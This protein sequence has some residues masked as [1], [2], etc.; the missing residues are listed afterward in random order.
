MRFH[1]LALPNVQTTRE[2]SL[3]GFCVATIRFAKLLKSLGHE[4]ILYA[5]EEN[6]APCDELVTV[7]T[8]E[9]IS[10][11]LGATRNRAGE[12]EVTPYQYA[13]IEEW[14][15]IW[16]LANAR[17]IR[18]ISKRKQ[19][20]DFI[21]SIGGSSQQPVARALPD[22]MFVEYSIGYL[23]SFSDFRVFESRAWQHVVYGQQNVQC[24]RFFDTVIPCSYDEV[25]FP[26]RAEKEPFALYCGRL[27]ER[28]GLQIA[29]QAAEA[30]GVPLKIIGH[31]DKSLVTHG[32]EYL[33][34]LPYAEKN[35]WLSRAQVVLTPTTYIE[36]FNQ[37]AVE[38]QL[39]GTPVI[40]TEQGGFTETI[41]HGVTGYHCNYLGEFVR[42]IHDAA[43]LDPVTIRSR[44]IRKYSIESVKHQYQAYFD[45]LYLLH[46]SGW[47]SLK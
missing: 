29:C 41:R 13:H 7:I 23:G 30:A 24:V 34:A 27:I 2:Y 17:M 1:L 31:G 3:C 16:Q 28:K 46:G 35:D 18:E 14:S 11:L 19:P 37:V 47:N 8:K 32:A 36:P 9:E 6:E 43:G 22:M 44:A 20:L 33:G 15:P 26:Y 5:S 25:D 38:A 39:C 21:C 45:R 10:S 4:V 42:A 40:S 12:P